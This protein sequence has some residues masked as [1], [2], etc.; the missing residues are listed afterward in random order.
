MD[1]P[2]D[3][4]NEVIDIL[5]DSDDSKALK[6]CTSVSHSFRL[7]SRKLLFSTITI[8]SPRLV[9]ALRSLLYQRPEVSRLIQKLCISS[10]DRDTLMQLPLVLPRLNYVQHLE[11]GGKNG[12]VRLD[13]ILTDYNLMIMEV[14]R[15]PQIHTL[16]LSSIWNFP[17]AFLRIPPHLTHLNMM[18][19][20]CV[21]SPRLESAITILNQPLKSVHIHDLL[22]IPQWPLAESCGFRRLV[23]GKSGQRVQPI[24][25][26]GSQSIEEII[27]RNYMFY[28]YGSVDFSKLQN[29]RILSFEILVARDMETPQITLLWE[30]ITSLLKQRAVAQSLEILNFAIKP[31]QTLGYLERDIVYFGQGTLWSLLA[32]PSY[33]PRMRKVTVHLVNEF[34]DS[35]VKNETFRSAVSQ[36]FPLLEATGMLHTKLCNDFDWT[37]FL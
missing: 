18:F 19:V 3:M 8:D 11:L 13:K 36:N 16:S 4:I 1:I 15:L 10:L 35:P 34:H 21:R 23:M 12:H 5:Y 6:A 9:R 7:R 32:D 27:W 22:A 24:V 30:S 29:L 14:L 26:A 37:N 33:F 2:Q 31:H 20:E 25:D 28:D 17:S